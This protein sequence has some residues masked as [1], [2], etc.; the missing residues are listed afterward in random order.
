VRRTNRINSRLHRRVDGAHCRSWVPRTAN[1]HPKMLVGTSSTAQGDACCGHRPDFP[2]CHRRT[3]RPPDSGAEAQ[4]RQARR[5]NT[6]STGLVHSRASL[7]SNA[8]SSDQARRSSQ[9][10]RRSISVSRAVRRSRVRFRCCSLPRAQWPASSKSSR[11]KSPGCIGELTGRAEKVY[12][13]SPITSG[14]TFLETRINAA[15]AWV[16]AKTNGRHDAPSRRRGLLPLRPS[17]TRVKRSP[18]SCSAA[19]WV[20]FNTDRAAP[21]ETP[22]L[23]GPAAR[24][25]RLHQARGGQIICTYFDEKRS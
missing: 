17:P 9:G 14:R 19:T 7:P 4:W 21:G 25:G 12:L 11:L 15:A 24:T 6:K 10:Q 8:P 23:A 20:V 13:P 1:V 22:F 5:G 18:R 3:V 16:T 2:A